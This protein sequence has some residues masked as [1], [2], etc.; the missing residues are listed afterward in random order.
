MSAARGPG[1]A[2]GAAFSLWAGQVLAMR[3]KEAEPK[4][5]SSNGSQEYSKGVPPTSLKPAQR[6]AHRAGREQSR[7][8]RPKDFWQQA[9]VRRHSE[10]C[11]AVCAQAGNLVAPDDAQISEGN[12]LWTGLSAAPPGAAVVG[13]SL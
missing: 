6:T 1:E 11:I 10:L 9:G 5:R 3:R 12:S 2:V 13:I 4:S 7:A 8:S